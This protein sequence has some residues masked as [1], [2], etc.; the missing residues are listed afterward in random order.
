MVND[1]AVR[2]MTEFQRRFSIEYLHDFNATRSIQRVQKSLNRD[3]SNDQVAGAM[4]YE[5]LNTP[6]VSQAIEEAKAVISE[7]Q[8]ITPEWVAA[9]AKKNVTQARLF[10][11]YGASNGALTLLSKYTG[12]FVERSAK[13]VQVQHVKVVRYAS[14]DLPESLQ[15]ADVDDEQLIEGKW[16]ELP[17]CDDDDAVAGQPG[18]DKAMDGEGA[19]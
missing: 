13:S 8:M 9:E 2:K 11:Q 7:A 10:A 16:L 6:H 18:D 17:A 3:L 1:V 14:N 5:L 15:A 12:G 4:G 19:S